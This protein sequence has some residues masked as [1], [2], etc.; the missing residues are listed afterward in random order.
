M[1]CCF[2][3]RRCIADTC[4]ALQTWLLQQPHSRL[5]AT[6]SRVPYCNKLYVVC[7]FASRRCIADTCNALQRWEAAV[8]QWWR[9]SSC[10]ELRSQQCV[11]NKR[12]AVNPANCPPIRPP[13]WLLPLMENDTVDVVIRLSLPRSVSLHS[14][15]LK[16]EHSGP[17][18]SAQSTLYELYW[19]TQQRTDISDRC[20]SESG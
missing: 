16:C 1:V 13:T 20:D 12:R 7:C 9:S 19:E 6:T 15:T 10:N 11:A 8:M 4:N 18:V 14:V 3:S 2:A 17:V 5:I